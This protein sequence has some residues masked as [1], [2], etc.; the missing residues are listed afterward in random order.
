MNA[1]SSFITLKV[2]KDDSRKRFDKIIRK[3]LPHLPLSALYSAIRKGTILLNNKKVKAYEKVLYGDSIDLS[4]QFKPQLTSSLKQ[5]PCSSFNAEQKQ[6]LTSLTL[7]ENQDLMILNKPRGFLVHGPHSLANLVE[8]YW[9]AQNK[10]A[11]SFKPG[12]VH[13]LDRNTTGL[14]FFALSVEGARILSSLFKDARIHKI[15]IA[16]ASGSIKKE[17]VWVDQILRNTSAKKS[18]AAR[19]GQGL[20][21]VT[22]IIPVAIKNDTSCILCL[23]ETGRTHQI[24]LQ[25]QIHRHS[26]VGD[27]KYGSKLLGSAYIL[28]AYA[29]SI[30]KK[31]NTL[32]IPEV[33]A[34]LP[35]NSED[36]FIAAMN[37]V[38]LKK[39]YS[40]VHTM[41]GNENC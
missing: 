19:S 30:P 15:Y 37:K 38:I 32:L 6:F 35:K 24:R 5:S 26:L 1:Q 25:A 13:R 36:I 14:Q 9:K 29:I 34:P 22:R 12:P 11:L 3:L 20:K 10:H 17:Q 23:P 27:K 8:N 18:F 4:L 28:H 31:H 39:A 40:M 7:F 21:A 16:L 41:I 2:L 33:F